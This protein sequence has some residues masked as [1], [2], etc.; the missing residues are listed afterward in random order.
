MW[1]SAIGMSFTWIFAENRCSE[2]SRKWIA[3][4]GKTSTP[5]TSLPGSSFSRFALVIC[6]ETYLFMAEEFSCRNSGTNF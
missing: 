3:P 5:S 1:Y 4:S 6:S 2:A